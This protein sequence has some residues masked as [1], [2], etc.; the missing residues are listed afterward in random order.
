MVEDCTGS[1]WS[2]IGKL[3]R[4]DSGVL[5]GLDSNGD[6]DDRGYSRTLP[7]LIHVCTLG[8]SFLHVVI[9]S[10]ANDIPIHVLTTTWPL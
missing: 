9:L 5:P 3:D 4:A 8:V 6:D 2:S 10:F 1:S 7:A